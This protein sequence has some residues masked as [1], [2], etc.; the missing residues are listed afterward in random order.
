MSKNNEKKEV[1]VPIYKLSIRAENEPKVATEGKSFT[2]KFFAKNIGDISFPGGNVWIYMR[3]SS[4]GNL[5]FYNEPIEI[6]SPIEPNSELQFGSVMPTALAAG[7]AL[8]HVQ[9]AST[10]DKGQMQFF[11]CEGKQCFPPHIGSGYFFHTVRIQT[12]EEIMQRWE[13]RIAFISLL[14]VA[15]SELANWIIKLF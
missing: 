13:I 1:H 7:Y 12:H 5:I 9:N 6:S 14:I 8:F 2:I 10:S 11:T 3:Y 4:L 15:V